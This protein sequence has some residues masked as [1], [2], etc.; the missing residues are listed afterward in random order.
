MRKFS[1]VLAAAA[2]VVALAV[3]GSASAKDIPSNYEILTEGEILMAGNDGGEHS[4]TVAYEGRIYLC[5]AYWLTLDQT[6][7]YCH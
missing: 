3:S 6:Q 7:I 1:L 5:L 2:V 4:F